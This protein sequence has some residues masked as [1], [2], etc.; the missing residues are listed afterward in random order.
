MKFSTYLVANHIL[1]LLVSMRV[2]DAGI[3][4]IVTADHRDRPELRGVDLGLEG[5]P[6]DTQSSL[7]SRIRMHLRP[8]LLYREAL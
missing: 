2:K 3:V 4:Y 8:N 5:R 1:P 7:K 6:S